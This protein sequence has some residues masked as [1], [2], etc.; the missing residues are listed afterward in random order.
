MLLFL[1]WRREVKEVNS[2]YHNAGIYFELFVF[3]VV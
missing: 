1:G 2:N 3:V